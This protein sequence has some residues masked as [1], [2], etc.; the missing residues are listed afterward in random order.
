MG[1]GHNSAIKSYCLLLFVCL[2]EDHVTVERVGLR[3]SA[4]HLAVVWLS[5]HFEIKFACVSF[6]DV[7]CSTPSTM[8]ARSALYIICFRCSISFSAFTFLSPSRV[9]V[10]ASSESSFYCLL[11]ELFLAFYNIQKVNMTLKVILLLHV[12]LYWFY[13][14]IAC[15]YSI[16]L[17]LRFL[18]T[19][20]CNLVCCFQ[21]VNDRVLYWIPHFLS[22]SWLD[23]KSP[24][25]FKIQNK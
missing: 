11:R 19:A 17:L 23:N 1:T 8:A 10:S 15:S 20:S 16:D 7:Q 9:P 6:F 18:D 13:I 14:W 3:L 25:Q 22:T 12:K 4:W 21:F 5:L 24:E 2:W